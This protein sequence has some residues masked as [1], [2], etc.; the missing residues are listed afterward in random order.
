MS[1][2]CQF[3]ILANQIAAFFSANP[4]ARWTSLAGPQQLKLIANNSQGWLGHQCLEIELRQ[5]S[6]S[7]TMF[8]KITIII[9]AIK[10]T[11]CQR[12]IFTKVAM[13]ANSVFFIM[14]KCLGLCATNMQ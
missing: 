11:Q 2:Q 14:C 9:A 8:V 13:C 7:E 10:E 3:P 1:C 5:S 12:Q 4:L 6:W